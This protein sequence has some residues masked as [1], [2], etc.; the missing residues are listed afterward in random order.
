MADVLGLNVTNLKVQSRTVTDP[1]TR[2]SSRQYVVSYMV[3][4]HGPFE[5]T[6]TGKDYTHENVTAA[7]NKQVQTLRSITAAQIGT[8]QGG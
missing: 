4:S 1:T 2:V 8:A 3:G 7:I 5:D 6:F